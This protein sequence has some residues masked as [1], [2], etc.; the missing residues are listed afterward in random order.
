MRT[1]Y[2]YLSIVIAAI[3]GTYVGGY[4]LCIRPLLNAAQ[5]FDQDAL[6][7]V[8]IMQTIIK[9][10]FACP[11]GFAI[12]YLIIIITTLIMMLINKIEKG[13]RK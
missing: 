13:L 10:V 6:T 8:I 1:I 3:A 12:F 4:L 11:V 5:L 9:C 2:A 7:G